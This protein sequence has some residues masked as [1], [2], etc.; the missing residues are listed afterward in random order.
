MRTILCFFDLEAYSL[1]HSFTCVRMLLFFA[2]V[3]SM[4]SNGSYGCREWPHLQI[5]L[6]GITTSPCW[7]DSALGLGRSWLPWQ[8]QT[9]IK[10]TSFSD[11]IWFGGCGYSGETRRGQ[12]LWRRKRR[13][14]CFGRGRGWLLLSVLGKWFVM[15]PTN[16][17]QIWPTQIGYTDPLSKLHNSIVHGQTELTLLYSV[18]IR[19][20]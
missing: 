1:L 18:W 12:S 19:C 13:H 8:Q 20:V 16:P 6:G 7:F 2:P 9:P 17:I 15:L 5:V 11:G 4:R 10:Q 3:C 14:T